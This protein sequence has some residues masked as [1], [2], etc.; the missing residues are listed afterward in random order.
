MRLSMFVTVLLATFVAKAEVGFKN[1][2]NI[3][4]VLSQ[5]EITV[6]CQDS[7]MPGGPTFGAFRCQEEILLT[8]EYD[9]F[10]GPQGV[11]GDNVSLTATHEDGSQR[12]KSVGY[13]SEKGQ[14][15]KTIN[16]WIATLLQRPL[17][18]PGKNV[19]AYKISLDGKTTSSGQFVATVKD[20]GRKVCSRRGVYWSN[21]SSDCQSG[22]NMCWRYF[23]ENNYCL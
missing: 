10:V 13:D 7:G 15:T 14:S 20:G 21:N 18:N 9:Y 22:N 6:H 23:Q 17:L 4:A 5:G 16:L 2:N 3:T 19:V 8:G 11:K 1:G 12:T